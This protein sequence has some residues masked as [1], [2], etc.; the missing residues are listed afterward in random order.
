[1]PSAGLMSYTVFMSFPHWQRP[2]RSA[3]DELLATTTFA[4]SI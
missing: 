4:F 3:R 1:L 2:P